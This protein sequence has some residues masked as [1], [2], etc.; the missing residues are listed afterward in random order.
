MTFSFD[1]MPEFDVLKGDGL[2]QPKVAEGVRDTL[3]IQSAETVE[4]SPVGAKFQIKSVTFVAT[5]INDYKATVVL[6]GINED[7]L[8]P[9]KKTISA[10][11]L[12]DA[13]EA[14]PLN[15]TY[16][17]PDSDPTSKYDWKM[18]SNFKGSIY[19]EK[20]TNQLRL[21]DGRLRFAFNYKGVF[22]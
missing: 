16:T 2:V 7:L 17:R 6:V 19:L 21:V 12:A 9:I 14:N 5:E 8:F 11:Q 13:T 10:Q 20:E 4:D 1:P 22:L 18:L 15:L 3:G